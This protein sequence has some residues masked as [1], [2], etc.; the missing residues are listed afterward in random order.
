MYH[1]FACATTNLMRK[2]TLDLK[3]GATHPHP[4]GIA[5]PPYALLGDTRLAAPSIKNPKERDRG[6]EV[7]EFYSTDSGSL[8]R[9]TPSLICYSCTVL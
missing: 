9:W 3:H 5:Q 4:P 8:A 6:S 2:L 7:T 1:S